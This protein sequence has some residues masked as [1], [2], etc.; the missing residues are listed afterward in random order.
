MAK[1]SG[2]NVTGDLYE[3]RV[4][5]LL[6]EHGLA[7]N[8]LTGS[9]SGWDLHCHVPEGLY[10][11][12]STA[13]RASW[14]LSG[15]S[16]HVQ[17]KSAVRDRLRVGTVRGWI[18]GT[19]SGVPTL[20][21][22]RKGEQA[23]FSSPS[24]LERWLSVASSHADDDSVHHYTLTGKATPKQTPLATHPYQEARFPSVL[25]LWVRYPQLALALEGVTAWMNH[26]L[27][28]PNP[29]ADIVPEFANAVW[30]DAGY[31]S[32]TE[33]HILERSLATLYSAAGFDDAEHRATQYLLAGS[34][35]LRLLGDSRFTR[36]TVATVAALVD[37]QDPSGSASALLQALVRLHGTDALV[38]EAPSPAYK[39][40]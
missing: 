12:A 10:Q 38:P 35:A 29:L 22:A 28:A 5:E 18:T 6:L 1:R 15:R 21:F 3:L 17:V 8:A 9:D 20:L 39:S 32:H 34:A 37:N 19:A 16:A 25:Q 31:G 2:G 4:T 30:A 33:D 27:D 7:I 11:R 23:R 36:D 24:D 40:V 14:L 26:E 13:G